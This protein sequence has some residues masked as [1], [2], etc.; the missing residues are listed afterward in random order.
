MYRQK[1]FL[2]ATFVS[3]PSIGL[4]FLKFMDLIVAQTEVNFTYG[5]QGEML[6]TTGMVSLWQQYIFGFYPI[7]IIIISIGVLLFVY[8]RNPH[9]KSN[10]Q[11]AQTPYTSS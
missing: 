5:S 10:K 4:L 3:V 11:D 1:Y 8:Q 6:N 7:A 9:N 2:S